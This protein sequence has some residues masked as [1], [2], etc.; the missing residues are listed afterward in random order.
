MRTK[1]K[2]NVKTAAILDPP[3]WISKFFQNVRKPPKVT[4]KYS[5]S[6][7]LSLKS[8]KGGK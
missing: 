1:K 3:S 8:V 6:I 4:A 7:K 2:K 5:E